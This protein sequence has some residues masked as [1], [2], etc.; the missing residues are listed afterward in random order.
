VLGNNV[1]A[2]E[3]YARCRFVIE[4]VLRDEFLLD[5]HYVDGVLMARSLI[6]GS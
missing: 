4:G 5:R 2:R 1:V 3:L 6:D